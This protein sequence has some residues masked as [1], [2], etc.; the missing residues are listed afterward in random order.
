MEMHQI[1]Y[2]LAVERARN[3]SRAAEQCNITQPALT[4]AIQK[5]ED[6]VGGKLFH[7]RPG[8][9]ELTELGRTL[10]PR[11]EHAYQEIASAR[12]DALDLVR[13]RRQRLRLGVMCTIGPNRLTNLIKPV[14]ASIP[15]LELYLREAKGTDVIADLTSDKI[16]VAVVGLP[17]YPQGTDAIRL[18]DEQ[19]VV[20]V[21]ANHRFAGSNS[22]QLQELDGENYIERVNCE[23]DDHFDFEHGEWPIDLNLRYHSEREDWVQ[24]M[25]AAGIGIAIMPQS[26]PLLPGVSAAPLVAPQVSRTIS[27]VTM[28]D[29]ALPPAALEFTRLVKSHVWS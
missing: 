6:E 12:S 1:R 3:F 11:L 19:Y 21:P 24:A 23:F 22:V 29:R 18:Y 2:F 17:H 15:G 9:I 25:I 26:F 16:D 13:Q 14:L 4:R 8:N 28:N 27:L 10:L 7:R 20:A 5:L